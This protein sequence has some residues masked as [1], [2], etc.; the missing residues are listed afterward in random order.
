MWFPPCAAVVFFTNARFRLPMVSTVVWLA[1]VAVDRLPTLRQ[2]PRAAV[3]ALCA[4][5][6]GAVVTWGNFWGVRQYRIP[7]ID[8]NTGVLAREA[9]DLP[10]ATHFLRAGLAADPSDPIGWVH[11][12]LALEA[13]GDSGAAAIAYQDA[14]GH[15]PADASLRQM[16]GRFAAR[17]PDL[18]RAPGGD[19]Q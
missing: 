6:I 1:A 9:G 10:T 13:A 12:A 5:L 3:A 4:A 11:L 7:Q 18:L 2:R 8:V 14:L 15:V 16:A 19:F 17:H